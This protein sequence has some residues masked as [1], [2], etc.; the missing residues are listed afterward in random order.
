MSKRAADSP[1]DN[2][3]K[4]IRK[5]LSLLIAHKIELLHKLDL[6]ILLKIMVWE[7]SP[8]TT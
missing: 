6:D 5:H 1:M 3:E 4:L 2:S 7:L 8:Y